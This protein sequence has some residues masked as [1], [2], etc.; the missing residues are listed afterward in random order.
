MG[1]VKKVHGIGYASQPD[2]QFRCDGKW[3]QPAWAGVGQSMGSDGRI[4]DASGEPLTPER[5]YLSDEDDRL[6]SFDE[7]LVTC[8]ACRVSVSRV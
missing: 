8:E 1:P 6:F 5:V 7:S 4:R 2:H 3:G